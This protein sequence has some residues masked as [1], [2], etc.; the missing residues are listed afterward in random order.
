A[1]IDHR[2]GSV[3]TGL[4]LAE[5]A[6]GGTLD[7]HVHSYEE[8][9]YILSGEAIVAINDHTYRLQRGDYGCLKVGTVHAWRNGGS[10]PVRWLQMAAPQPKPAGQERD[11]FFK[12]GGRAPDAGERLDPSDLKGSLLSHFDESQIP[13]GEEGRMVSGGLKGVF[14]KW[15][16]DE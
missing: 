16:V 15:L 3:H 7:P 6:P 9:F 1:L 14:L 13:A 5:L 10:T 12:K 11:T 2:S 4:G 8:S